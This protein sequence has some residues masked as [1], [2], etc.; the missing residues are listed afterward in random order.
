MNRFTT[1]FASL[2]GGFGQLIFSSG[3]RF[4]GCSLI[5]VCLLVNTSGGADDVGQVGAN[6]G[7]AGAG[8]SEGRKTHPMEALLEFAKSRQDYI[9]ENISDYTCW[10]VK[11]ERLGGT[12]QP[13]QYARL[14]VRCE[15]TD[16]AGATTPLAVYM[17]YS[18]PAEIRDRRV[19]Y[20][21]DRENGDVLVRKGGTLLSDVKISLDPNSQAARRESNYPITEVGFDKIMGRLIELAR[22]DI[23]VDPGGE[24]TTVEY[25]EKAKVGDRV[26][27]RIQIEHPVFN[28]KF[29]FHQAQLFIDDEL[30][31]PVRLVVYDWPEEQGW[32]PSLMEEY[33]YLRLKLNVGLTE[34][35]FSE[36][37]LD[38]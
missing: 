29:K 14:S 2:S 24:N 3:S 33:T 35:D 30:R 15:R 21:S 22:Q 6:E 11:R 28:D 25:F 27:T 31:M 17:R 26:C 8:I 9:R 20:V 38:D 32:E 13:Y 37:L 1:A 12:L 23:A 18:R 19:L 5:A 34:A 36:S 7:G 10:L 4:F 16:A